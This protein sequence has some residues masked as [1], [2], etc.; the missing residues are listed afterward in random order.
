ML[1][2]FFRDFLLAQRPD[3]VHVQHTIFLGY[4][5]LRVIRNTLPDVPIVYTLHE[6]LPICFRDGQM[7]RTMA[8]RSSAGR[9]RRAAATSASRTQ[10][11]DLLHAQAVHPVP[12]DARRPLHRAERVRP[13]P[14]RG[15]GHPAPSKITVE[16]QGMRP[17]SDR[18]AGR[19]RGPRR[20]TASRSS[21]SSTPTRAP[22]C[23]SRRWSILG[24]DFDGHLSDL[25]R[26]P[27]DPADRV[28]ERV[29][30]AARATA[31]DV[32]FAGA[33]EHA[34]PA[35]ADG[36]DR[37]GGGSLDLVGDRADGGRWRHSSTAAR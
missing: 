12:P 18:L 6:Y 23:C 22:T 16:P 10:P 33:Y 30:R 3:I 17:S 31:R 7:V 28:P 2:R 25:R 1:T 19:A 35:E 21:A 24:D 15:L 37:L 29:R 5:V 4:D 9:S 14:L 34:R 20:A 13:R 27:G 36:R 8:T 32:T 26:Q 11:A